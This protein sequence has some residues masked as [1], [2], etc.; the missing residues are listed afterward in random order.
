MFALTQGLGK[1]QGRNLFIPSGRDASNPSGVRNKEETQLKARCLPFLE[2]HDTA[3]TSILPYRSSE[4]CGTPSMTSHIPAALPV[5]PQKMPISNFTSQR[6]A[7]YS[8]DQ[9]LLNYSE[10]LFQD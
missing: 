8:P 9:L 2:P 10:L 1:T 7:V 3:A 5:P 4:V 6:A